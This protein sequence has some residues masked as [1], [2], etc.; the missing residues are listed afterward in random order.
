MNIWE[1]LQ[2]RT[3]IRKFLS[4]SNTVQI[5]FSEQDFDLI[6]A[7]AQ[8]YISYTKNMASKQLTGGVTAMMIIDKLESE[9]D[10]S[11]FTE[12]ELRSIHFTLTHLAEKKKEVQKQASELKK[13]IR[14]SIVGKSESMGSG[15][16]TSGGESGGPEESEV[17]EAY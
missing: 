13:K 2:I 1:E 15:N 3:T 11:K 5:K 4:E 7:A 17:E 12:A 16:S 8:E 10:N 14:S 9:G 6:Y